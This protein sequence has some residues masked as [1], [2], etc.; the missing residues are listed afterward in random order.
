[1][2]G[3]AVATLVNLFVLPAVCLII[4]VREVDSTTGEAPEQAPRADPP[5][6]AGVLVGGS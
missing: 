2:V 3:L 4:G 1:M 6:S 5:S